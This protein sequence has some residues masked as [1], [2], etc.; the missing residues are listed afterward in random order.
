[1]A[2]KV[3]PLIPLSIHPVFNRTGKSI[4]QALQFDKT[5]SLDALELRDVAMPVL[6][7][8]DVLVKVHAAGINPSDI[9]NVLGRFPYTTLPRI[10]GR[11]FSGIVIG[12]P[13]EWKG[14]N[15]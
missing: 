9:K 5:G 7:N 1:M 4:M 8:G 3:I 12:G 6:G 11:D 10:P 15:V 13:D 14:K 2:Q